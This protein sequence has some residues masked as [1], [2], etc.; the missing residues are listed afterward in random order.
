MEF[1][2][3][4]QLRQVDFRCSA[5]R[6]F[7]MFE[8]VINLEINCVLCEDISLVLAGSGI[9]K[10]RPRGHIGA[11]TPIHPAQMTKHLQFYLGLT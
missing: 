7:I 4:D 6:I 5:G 11:V 1:F 3:C 8:A 2:F 9:R 10:L